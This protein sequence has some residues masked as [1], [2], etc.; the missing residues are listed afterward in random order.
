MENVI[1]FLH[2]AW[3]TPLCWEHFVPYFEKKGYR[4]L[5]PPWPGK[6]A[7]IDH[8]RRAP[9]PMLGGLGIREIV[10]HYE[11]VIRR[12]PESP[13]LVGH[14]FGGLFVQILLDRGLGSAGVAIDSAPPAGIFSFYPTA[15][16]SLG[17]V[18]TTWMGWKRI[19]RM[20]FSDFRYAFLNTVPSD[21]QQPVYDRYVVPE[22]GR[23]F[24][25]AA[26][27]FASP[28]SP[29]RVDF[30]NPG[31]PPLLLIAGG[32]DHIV[33]PQINRANYRK[34]HSPSAKTDF[35]EFP[36]R[37]HWILAEDGWEQV[38]GHIADWLAGLPDRERI[39]A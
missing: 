38:A 14:S 6:E 10:E 19:L 9:S 16:R 39:G 33:P 35:K 22:T 4:T 25:Q 13:V 7:A 3:V 8:Q 34:Y 11:S 37:G 20:P 21:R 12:L 23:V 17:R 30:A 27:S 26:L 28:N 36:G 31:R 1:V 24:F 5:A 2:G 32:S 29:A 18:L 15:F